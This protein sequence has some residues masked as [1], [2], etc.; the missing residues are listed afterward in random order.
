MEPRLKHMVLDKTRINAILKLLARA[1]PDAKI[2]LHHRNPLQLLISTI[3]S[4]QCTD[5]RVNM[6]TPKLFATYPDAKALAN[7]KTS[8]LEQIIRSTG[9]Y[10]AKAKSIQSSCKTLVEKYNG[11]VPQ[12]I[13]DLTSLHGVA[14]KTA[15]VVLGSAFGIISGIVVDTHVKRLSN[16]LALTT[17]SDPVKIEQDLMDKIPRSKWIKFSHQ[18]ILHGRAICVARKPKCE[19]CVLSA[20]CPFFLE[21]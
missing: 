21:Q 12:N 11:K 6:V 19:A 3:L 4:A 2:A 13:D 17:N 7:A 10:R 1:Y 5:V 18:L 9:F 14:R 15:N 20:H 8:D 16:R